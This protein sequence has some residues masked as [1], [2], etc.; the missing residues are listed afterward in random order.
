M[1]SWSVCQGVVGEQATALHRP[2]HVAVGVAGRVCRSLRT[3]YVVHVH[4][5]PADDFN[6]IHRPSYGR[7][8]GSVA[9]V[10]VAL[11][12]YVLHLV[13][14]LLLLLAHVALGCGRRN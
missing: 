5:G 8:C 13:A 4:F 11:K 12:H 1:A 3:E 6:S 10:G 2:P 14:N 7:N 9:V